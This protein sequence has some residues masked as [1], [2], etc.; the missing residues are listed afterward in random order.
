MHIQ[1]KKEGI[2]GLLK[3]KNIVH[4]CFEHVKKL[5]KHHLW[6]H[7][8]LNIQTLQIMEPKKEKE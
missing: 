7:Q 5:L 6:M 3:K 8:V 1:Q 2:F 4:N